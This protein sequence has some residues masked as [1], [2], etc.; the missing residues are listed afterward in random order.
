MV[1][2]ST[3]KRLRFEIFKRDSFKCQYCGAQP[4]NV[5]LVIDHVHPVAQG[6]DND[7]I[8]LITSCEVCNQGKSDRLLGNIAPRPD[9]DLE[10]L[11]MQQ[12]IAELRR[13]QAARVERDDMITEIAIR[14]SEN[15]VQ[16]SG[17]RV[18]ADNIAMEIIKMLG[19]HS[20]EFV[21]EALIS[22]AR[23]VSGG[24]LSIY[25]WI[26]YTYGILKNMELER[27]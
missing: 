27:R 17:T 6:G 12:E 22:T 14:L 21:E 19:K 1:R 16:E 11:Q 3:G 18:N 15:F 20:P 9:A 4:P 26:P 24:Y 8:N 5:V 10:W 7:P 25:A 13:Y 2:K 23:K